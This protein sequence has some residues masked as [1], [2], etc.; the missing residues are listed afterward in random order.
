MLDSLVGLGFITWWRYVTT[1]SS[2]ELR[3]SL[4]LRPAT[5][6]TMAT[7]NPGSSG[8]SNPTTQMTPPAVPSWN[9]MS[10]QHRPPVL[11]VMMLTNGST[12]YDCVSLC[13]RWTDAQ[14][15]TH[16]TFYLT[17]VH[18]FHLSAPRRAAVSSSKGQ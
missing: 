10:P 17:S 18:H 4:R 9:V 8:A 14:E 13:T 6:T 3:S 12:N 7:S 15:L 2:L 11:A 1:P 5:P 16:V